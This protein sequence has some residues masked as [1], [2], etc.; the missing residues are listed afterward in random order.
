MWIYCSGCISADNVID[1]HMQID[2]KQDIIQ[3]CPCGALLGVTGE[4]FEHYRGEAPLCPTRLGILTR[5]SMLGESEANA[6][7]MHS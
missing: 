2:V 3:T 5:S 4:V 1:T 7:T 6:L